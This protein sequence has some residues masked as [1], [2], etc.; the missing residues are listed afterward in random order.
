MR[1]ESESE[2]KNMTL[3]L[4]NRTDLRYIQQLRDHSS[5]QNHR[6]LPLQNPQRKQKALRPALKGHLPLPRASALRIWICIRVFIFL[7]Y[8]ESP[9]NPAYWF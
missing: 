5:T 6:N 7:E 2:E 8:E 9:T 3:L 1:A 4:E